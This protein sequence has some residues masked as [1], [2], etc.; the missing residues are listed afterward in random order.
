[1]IEEVIAAGAV[2]LGIALAGI[3]V[4][5]CC[6]GAPGGAGEWKCCRPA[7]DRSR[8]AGASVTDVASCTASPVTAGGAWCAAPRSV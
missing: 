1:M 4:V 2:W 3:L 7:P 8:G 6:C 5:L